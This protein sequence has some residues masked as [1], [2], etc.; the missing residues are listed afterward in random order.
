M[1]RTLAAFLASGLLASG[2]ALSAQTPTTTAQSPTTTTAD[3]F[4]SKDITVTGCVEKTKSGGYFLMASPS[5]AGAEAG[6]A[7]TTG[8]S[9]STPP[10]STTTAGSA[11]TTTGGAS[12]TTADSAKAAHAAAWNLGQSDK[13]AQY[14]GQ[15]ISVTGRPEKETSGDQVKGTKGPGEIQARD[16]DVK[17]VT[18][19]SSS[20]R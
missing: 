20:C 14:V 19:V 11:A 3:K 15:R 10:S 9:G 6:A 4:D 16:I 5:P 17:S 1:H 7:T 18:V 13:F 12:T 8:T 2:A